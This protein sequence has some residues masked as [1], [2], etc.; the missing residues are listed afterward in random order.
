VE[1]H[2]PVAEAAEVILL[3]AVVDL[4]VAVRVAGQIQLMQ[5]LRA[6]VTEE[7]ILEAAEAVQQFLILLEAEVTAGPE[8]L[9]L[10]GKY[11]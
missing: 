2:I 6:V 1:P 5:L 4:V 11:I 3:A 10:F 9:E 7:Q 8:S